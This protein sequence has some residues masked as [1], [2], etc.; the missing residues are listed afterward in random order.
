M[1]SIPKTFNWKFLISAFMKVEE[2]VLFRVV[3]CLTPGLRTFDIP[4]SRRQKIEKAISGLQRYYSERDRDAA[5]IA[6]RGGIDPQRGFRFG[7]GKDRRAEWF[8]SHR[9][10]SHRMRPYQLGELEDLRRQ[11]S[12]TAAALTAPSGFEIRVLVRQVVPGERIRVSLRI[13]SAQTSRQFPIS[14]RCRIPCLITWSKV[15][16][17]TR[18]G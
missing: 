3:Q 10:R 1:R 4:N 12:S 6:R 18:R 7:Y 5:D 13:V 8:K 9:A 16:L 15:K 11:S 14:N 2:L 17:L